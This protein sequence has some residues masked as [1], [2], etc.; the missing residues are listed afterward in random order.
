M[1]SKRY[2]K[3]NCSFNLQYLPS[4]QS[5]KTNWIPLLRHP[6]QAFILKLVLTFGLYGFCEARNPPTRDLS[7]RKSQLNLKVS[8]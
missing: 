3:I 1:A 2:L 8:I 7:S 4:N 6:F 5:L